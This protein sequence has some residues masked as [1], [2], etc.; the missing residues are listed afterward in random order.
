MP[1]DPI[2]KLRPW[3]DVRTFGP[4]GFHRWLRTIPPLLPP[5]SPTPPHAVDLEG[6]IAAIAR[7]LVESAG[8][9]VQAH[10]QASE[11]FRENRLLARRIKA[12]E[13]M[14]RTARIPA[15]KGTTE[16]EIAVERYLPQERSK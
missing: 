16:V 10:F 6:R 2:E 3:I 4:V 9:E 8:D 7:S 11:Y 5:S 14:L 1:A 12:L 13:A 15:P